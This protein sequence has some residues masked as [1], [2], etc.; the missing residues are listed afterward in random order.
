MEAADALRLSLRA[1]GQT[2]HLHLEPNENL[3]HPNGATVKYWGHDEQGRDVVVREEKIMPGETRA[4]HGHVVHPF[5]T[6][7]RIVEDR[8]GLRRDLN[9]PSWTDMGVMGPASM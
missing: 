4:Y 9:E 2:F 8:V 6:R 1:F 5:W 7:D 3:V